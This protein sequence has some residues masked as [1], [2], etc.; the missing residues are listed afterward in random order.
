M[1][2]AYS[3]I[4][5]STP[6]QARGDSL[7][8][9]IALAEHW[10][11]RN[12]LKIDTSLRD[13]GMSAH[14]GAQAEVGSA[15]G[16]FLDLVRRG[17][18]DVGSHLIV[19]SLD[20]LSRETILEALPRFISL[21]NAGIIIV[22]L[23]DEQVYSKESVNKNPYQLFASLAVMARAYEESAT[24]AFRVSQAWGKKKELAR[25]V[26][27]PLTQRCPEWL[28]LRDGKFV[29]RPERVAVVHQIFRETIHG[30]GRREIVRRLN[31]A[32]EPAF[33][34]RHGWHTSSIAKIIQSRAVL[35]EY[36]P[37][38]GTHR[39]RNRK[40][41]GEPI[42]DFYPRIVDE[43]TFALAQD[44]VQGRRQRAAGRKGK[45]VHL[46]QNLARCA[47]C[48]GAMHIRNHGQPPK[49]GIYLVC[50]SHERQSGCDNA[51][52]W[53]LDRLEPALLEALGFVDA[54]A[55]APLDDATPAAAKQI[56][57]A[58]AKLKAAD[59]RRKRWSDVL[60]DPDAA[61]DDEAK[62]RYAAAAAEVKA[63]RNEVKAAEA[64]AARLAAD[65]GLVARLNDVAALSRQIEDPDK[66][67]RRMLRIRLSELLRDLVECVAFRADIGAVMVLKPRLGPQWVDGIVPFA[68]RRESNGIWSALL[69]P[70]A[71]DDV[72]DTFL[73]WSTA[74]Q[75]QAPA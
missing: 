38:S 59:T 72:V 35:G 69:E 43:A 15:L 13:E 30:L 14:R 34:G 11:A 62:A 29:Q 75:G 50:S 5:F 60:D 54:Q 33:R 51:R 61:D 47:S 57:V 40:P 1:L 67:K 2:R 68:F 46:L 37:H 18:V 10:C 22:T 36:Q 7:R 25:T 17:Q 74:H 28:E 71:N 3:Y 66:E 49:G 9:Q 23:V 20:R 8:R 41:E 63:F 64:E 55:F 53:R 39:G 19:E 70:A 32:G 16:N 42:P 58:R 56:A 45:T 4:R 21:L 24:K 65:P 6:E 48:G 31:G 27:K 73:G 26:G 52:R 12:G 44:A